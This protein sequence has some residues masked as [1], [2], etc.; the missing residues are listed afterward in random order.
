MGRKKLPDNQRK[1]V[2]IR[3]RIE[4]EIAQRRNYNAIKSIAYAAAVEYDKLKQITENMKSIG[5][6]VTNASL[7]KV[8]LAN[9]RFDIK[10]K[11]VLYTFSVDVI[12]GKPYQLKSVKC[13][14]G[15]FRKLSGR[16]RIKILDSIKSAFKI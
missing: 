11:E 9:Y 4:N 10:H 3:F 12:L 13:L 1:D 16:E 8:T 15:A 2:I 6:N 7:D 5:H 14:T